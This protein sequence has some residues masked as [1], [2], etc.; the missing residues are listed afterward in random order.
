VS[1]PRTLA[2]PRDAGPLRTLPGRPI[3]AHFC[4]WPVTVR[5]ISVEGMVL[6]RWWMRKRERS[7]QVSS[8]RRLANCIGSIVARSSSSSV[9]RFF[10]FYFDLTSGAA[11]R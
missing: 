8:S 1:P 2:R 5:L 3:S 10:Y 4:D 6:R 9:D 7:G 11:R